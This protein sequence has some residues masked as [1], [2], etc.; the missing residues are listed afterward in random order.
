MIRFAQ[1]TT[2]ECDPSSSGSDDAPL[3]FLIHEDLRQT[4]VGMATSLRLGKR[5]PHTT[6][7][8]GFP[9][10]HGGFRTSLS[11]GTIGTT[12]IRFHSDAVM[13]RSEGEGVTEV[14]SKYRQA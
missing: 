7:R 4:A 9:D 3:G 13:I 11:D 12:T 10:M 8:E 14:K 1:P 2:A 5:I 6:L